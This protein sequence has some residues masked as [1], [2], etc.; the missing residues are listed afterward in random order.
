MA[1]YEYK[2]IRLKLPNFHNLPGTQGVQLVAAEIQAH[3]F[4]RIDDVSVD[5]L[6]TEMSRQGWELDK[7]GTSAETSALYIFKRLKG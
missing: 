6:L 1:M 4:M 7:V 3:G 2:Q 5:K